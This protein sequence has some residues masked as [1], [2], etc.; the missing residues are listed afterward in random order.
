MVPARATISA[1]ETMGLPQ[2]LPIPLHACQGGRKRETWWQACQISR[3]MALSA[4]LWHPGFLLSLLV[5]YF[6]CNSLMLVLLIWS[7]SLNRVIPVHRSLLLLLSLLSTLPFNFMVG[8]H[9]SSV[10]TTSCL[11]GQIRELTMSTLVCGISMQ[12]YQWIVGSGVRYFTVGK[13]FF[14]SISL[15]LC[16]T[17][18]YVSTHKEQLLK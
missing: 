12:S 17:C 1:L 7:S 8:F 10:Y 11:W 9:F 6:C 14:W 3:E 2:W 15:I 16:M 13:L 4:C 18:I 5:A